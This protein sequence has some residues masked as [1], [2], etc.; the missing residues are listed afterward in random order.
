MVSLNER[1]RFLKYHPGDY[2]RPHCD[3]AYARP[4]GSEMSFITIQ[5]Y[6]NNCNPN[7]GMM[8]KLLGSGEKYDFEGGATTFLTYSTESK[9]KR[10]PC[11]PKA[12]RVLVFEH[13]ILHEGSEVTKGIK[14]SMRTDIMYKRTVK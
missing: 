10:V 5:L 7:P 14:Y 11:Y 3:G 4:D 1:L 2:F 8:S 9:Q 6:L 12:G 13:K